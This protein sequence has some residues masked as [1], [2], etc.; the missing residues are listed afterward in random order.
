MTL[1]QFVQNFA[2]QFDETPA[3]QFTPSTDY[4]GLDEWGSLTALSV[5]TMVDAEM[6]KRIFDMK[7]IDRME[8]FV[9]NQVLKGVKIPIQDKP[10][11]KKEYSDKI[12]ESEKKEIESK[13]SKFEKNMKKEDLDYDKNIKNDSDY[14]EDFLEDE[15]DTFTDKNVIVSRYNLIQKK[16]REKKNQM[17]IL[18]NQ[19]NNIK[20]KQ[21]NILD[22]I[23]NSKSADIKDK[24][25]IDLV[26]KNQDLSLKIERHKLKE[27]NLTKQLNETE[28]KLNEVKTEMQN[29]EKNKNIPVDKLEVNSLKKNLKQT[30]THLT[31]VRN[32][33]QLTKEENVKLNILLK[34][35]V[36]D[37]F[38]INRA[39][40]DKNY[41]KPR[42]EIIEGLKAKIKSLEKIIQVN[43]INNLNTSNNNNST[44]TT[45][46]NLPLIPTSSNIVPYSQYKKEKEEMLTSIEKVKKDLNIMTEQNS[47]L[48]SRRNVL[49]K[50]LKSQ[51]EQLTD[52][53]KIL[54]EKSD[55]DEK[56][57]TALK[58]ELLKKGVNVGNFYES[59]TFNL[60][61][62]IS[63][64]KDKL[65]EKEKYINEMNAMF[66]P[67]S[68]NKLQKIKPMVNDTGIVS[69]SS[70]ID[71]ATL[72]AVM[73]RLAELEK[74]N[75]EL[76]TP[77]GGGEDSKIAESLARENA[78]LR[79]KIA[80][81]E[82]K[83]ANKK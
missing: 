18:K 48:K 56:L 22:T 73:N 41:F 64:L 9:D 26:K 80:D 53:I 13:I 11:S 3:D 19:L 71:D 5:I 7:D 45:G 63:K 78:K 2:E 76:E 49:E 46:V 34:R 6:E 43:N 8:N 12:K 66:I 39:L 50:E 67:E 60:K 51:K 75:K 52:K 23:K 21:N 29:L 25:L 83:L 16:L 65:K 68:G 47:K 38:D 37:S 28:K 70:K 55:N 35:E 1:D 54:L 58:S 33:L 4:K 42:A 59:E 10:K 82:D 36:G 57:I 30:E 62:E 79:M 40:T 24:K 20:N 17:E 15:I 31:D 72:T 81:L 44:S 32:K 77:G 14:E 27:S 61:Q 69:G 74:E